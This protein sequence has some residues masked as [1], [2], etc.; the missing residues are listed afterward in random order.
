MMSQ[1]LVEGGMTIRHHPEE[2][3][4][5]GAMTKIWVLGTALLMAVVPLSAHASQAHNKTA[6]SV[7][8]CRFNCDY[9]WTRH[10][11]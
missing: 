5:K 9:Y 1:R 4:R 2:F 3:C 7:G 6:K 8:V 11:G 10:K